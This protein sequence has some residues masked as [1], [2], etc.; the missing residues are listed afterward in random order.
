MISVLA[1]ISVFTTR[2][3]PARVYPSSSN[4]YVLHC[5]RCICLST[6][7]ESSTRF[8]PAVRTTSHPGAVTSTH[9]ASTRRRLVRAAASRSE[10]AAFPAED[11]FTSGLED[12]APRNS[13]TTIRFQTLSTTPYRGLLGRCGWPISSEA[14]PG[15]RALPLEHLPLLLLRLETEK[16]RSRGAKLAGLMLRR[17]RHLYHPSAAFCRCYKEWYTVFKWFLGVCWSML[18]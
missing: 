7:C 13:R 2:S 9:L 5:D 3:V 18:T 12:R 16:L 17:L 11:Q 8:Y 14:N 1:S 4:N 10:R 6:P 15:L